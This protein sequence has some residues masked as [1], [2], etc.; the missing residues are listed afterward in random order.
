MNGQT[1]LL[2]VGG[3]AVAAEATGV[4]NFTGG[5]S[6][7]GSG[8]GP[9]QFPQLPNIELPDQAAVELPNIDLPDQG[10]IALEMGRQAGAQA[11]P[12][13]EQV[14]DAVDEATDDVRERVPTRD[15]NSGGGGGGGGRD[16]AVE[17]AGAEPTTPGGKAGKNAG[18]AAWHG[19]IKPMAAAIDQN[20]PGFGGN[21]EENTKNA[22]RAVEDAVPHAEGDLTDSVNS[23]TGG[24]LTGDS[25]TNVTDT[26]ITGDSDS[27]IDKGKKAVDT[28]KDRFSG[29]D[30]PGNPKKGPG[31]TL[32]DNVSSGGGLTGSSDT[33]ITDTGITGDSDSVIDKG[34]GAIGGFL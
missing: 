22:L 32:V 28:A 19:A 25:D 27:V 13:A 15:D 33:N 31:K 34:K 29:Q 8:G 1:L 14:K 18:Q 7:G 26:G 12:T 3:G 5:D 10:D 24:G 17:P 9:A 6:G 21:A 4:T 16:P 20:V 2:A 23:A 11:V 30:P